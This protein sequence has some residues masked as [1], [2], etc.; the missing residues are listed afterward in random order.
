MATDLRP[1]GIRVVIGDVAI[2][3]PGLTGTV[4][5]HPPASAGMR[6]AEQA[7]AELLAA[8]GAADLDEQLTVEIA[9]PTELDDRGGSRASGGGDEIVLEVPGPGAGNG[10]V[11]LYCAEDGSLTW[12]VPE[13]VGAT[14]SPQRVATRGGERQTYRLPRAVVAPEAGPAAS[15]GLLGAIGT[16]L[17][18]VLVFPLIEPALGRMGN[19]FAARWEADHRPERVR[20]LTPDTYRAADAAPLG[21]D[22][23]MRARQGAALLF[24]HGTFSMCHTAFSG[25]SQ[26]TVAELH[27]RYAGR[28]LGWDHHTVS[29]SPRAN[30]RRLADLLAA[31]LDGGGPVTVDVLTHSRGG[32]VGRALAERGGE[33]GLGGLLQ[34]RNLVMVAPPNAGTALAD[35]DHL[36]S[37]LDRVTNLLQYLP[38]NGVTD[39]LGFVVSV[40]KQVAI[41]AFGGMEGLMSMNPHGP[42]LADFNHSPGSRATYRVV[43]SDF[44]PPAGSPLG[45]IA[46][47]AGTDIVFGDA[48]NDLVVPT[49]GAYELPD[50][51]GFP[52]HDPFVLPASAGVDHS[53]F[54]G[55]ADVGERLLAWLPG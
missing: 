11:L 29:V 30:V 50:T 38:D 46:R 31:A 2:T 47:N 35:R 52:V 44:E 1:E 49:T 23:W 41:G 55:R 20:W 26:Q 21:P 39:V 40:V 43:T 14:D 54:F 53:S 36:S 24:V 3:S 16:K 25:L 42:D 22:D 34:V 5:V 27:R 37:L 15:R 7:T 10:Q 18:K 28:V 33:L 17:F 48:P 19:A 8:L 9:Q 13:S 32:L 6:G 12:H 45:R 51:A 4:E